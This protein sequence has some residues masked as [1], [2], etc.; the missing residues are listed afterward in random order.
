MRKEGDTKQRLIKVAAKLIWEQSYGS[1]GI[2][3]ICKEAGV[4]KG[5]FYFAFHS[6]ADLILAAIEDHWESKRAQMDAIFSAQEPPVSRFEKY[7]DMIMADQKSK[8]AEY[9]KVCGCPVCSLGCELSTQD[10][11]IRRKSE[12]MMER[13][14]RYLTNAV[15]AL[16]AEG[17]APQEDPK[18]VA[19]QL[20]DYV[21]GLMLEAKIEN[22]LEALNRLKPGV[23]R[24]LGLKL[25]NSDVFSQAA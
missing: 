2:D 17:L 3:D 16:Q 13:I 8:W 6:K 7:C 25:S 12:E 23:F 19:R 20:Y 11:R 1:V 22:S 24:I 4:A 5:S 21:M 15:A 14:V 10:E 9:G 18:A